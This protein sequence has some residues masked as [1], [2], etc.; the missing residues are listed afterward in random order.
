MGKLC[1][2]ANNKDGVSL[3]YTYIDVINYNYVY[4]YIFIYLFIY[5][6]TH[7]KAA[8]A[9]VLPYVFL[10][11]V[12]VA[13]NLQGAAQILPRCTPCHPLPGA[14]GWQ[15]LQRATHSPSCWHSR[16]GTGSPQN[17]QLQVEKPGTG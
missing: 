15:G 4:I 5:L 2:R 13:K 11:P 10:L 14:A 9:D 12:R 17:P 8:L 6:F 7:I 1:L 3:C 16:C